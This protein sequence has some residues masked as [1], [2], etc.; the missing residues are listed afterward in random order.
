MPSPATSEPSPDVPASWI[1]HSQFPYPQACRVICPGCGKSHCCPSDCVILPEAL[2]E[3]TPVTSV[4]GLRAQ[5]YIGRVAWKR[6]SC[7]TPSPARIRV[8]LGV[9]SCLNGDNS[10]TKLP[11][12]CVDPVRNYAVYC[13]N[14]QWSYASGDS[15]KG[16]GW[17]GNY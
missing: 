12:F 14:T 2:A 3:L 17:V 4:K 15:G 10:E 8:D 5:Q 6:G 13:I 9:V 7:N 16:A 1:T 11:Q